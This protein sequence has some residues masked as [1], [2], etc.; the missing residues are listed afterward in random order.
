MVENLYPKGWSTT[1]TYACIKSLMFYCM[2]AIFHVDEKVVPFICL[3]GVPSWHSSGSRLHQSSRI[4]HCIPLHCCWGEKRKLRE[5]KER[6]REGEREVKER[7]KRKIR[8]DTPSLFLP[9][10]C[11][12]SSR[13]GRLVR[14]C[15]RSSSH[16][17]TV[18]TLAPL[19]SL[20][21]T[22]FSASPFLSGSH[23]SG[24]TLE[25]VKISY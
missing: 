7:E 18:R 1:C 3:L 16:C 15:T 25:V 24:P 23:P 5:E 8:S 11:V 21:S 13:C 19:L 9:Y 22:S 4:C 14:R 10:S 2:Q 6:G 20:T 17:W 12:V